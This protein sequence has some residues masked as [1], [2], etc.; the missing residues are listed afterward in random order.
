[1]ST[2]AGGD[3]ADIASGSR[4]LR[5][6]STHLRDAAP[7]LRSASSQASGAA[8]DGRISAALD[9]FGAAWSSYASGCAE[10]FSAASTLGASAAA[11]LTAADG[12]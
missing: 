6:V 8:G 5:T 3:T 11:D 10:Q 2:Y 1:M 12:G 9:R 4:G 7:P